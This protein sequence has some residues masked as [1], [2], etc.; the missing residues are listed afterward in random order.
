M[1]FVQVDLRT[2]VAQEK[3]EV[4]PPALRADLMTSVIIPASLFF[5][6][7]ACLHRLCQKCSM[8][9]SSATMDILFKRKMAEFQAA[10]TQACFCFWFYSVAG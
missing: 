2:K 10:M 3:S 4:L 9:G 7:L 6:G 5:V 1:L 8:R